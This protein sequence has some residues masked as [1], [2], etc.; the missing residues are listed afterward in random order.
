MSNTTDTN[1]SV[2][3][4]K[5]ILYDYIIRGVMTEDV[6]RVLLPQGEPLAYERQLWD[7]KT[8][9]PRLSGTGKH[10]KEELTT[11][12][13]EMSEIIKDAVAFYN[14]YGGYILIGAR[15]SP[16]E[17]VGFHGD[18]DCD[19]LNRSI[20]AATGRGIECFF[21]TFPVENGSQK[22]I[23]LGLLFIPQRP[24][25]EVP[26]QFCKDAAEKANG[27]KAYSKNDIYFRSNDECIAAKSCEDYAF[28]FT[29]GRRVFAASQGL[30]SLPILGSNLGPRDP[31]FIEFIG[32][33]DYLAALWNWFLDRYHPVKLL[34]GIGGVGKTA[35]AREFCEQFARV[36]PFGFQRIVWL[37]A[38]RQ[39]YT[40]ISGHFVSA[41]RV[42]FENVDGLLR[43]MCLEL[44]LIEGDLPADLAREHLIDAAIEVLAEMPAL[45]VIDDIDSLEPEQQQDVFHTLLTVFG[46]TISKSRVGSRALLT[47]RLDLGA[48][49]GQVIRVKGLKYEEFL[50][51]IRI[52]CGALELSL[53]VDRSSK[54]I[55]RFHRV[56]EGSPTFA[57]SIL[58]LVALGEGIDS[59]LTKWE[60]SDGEEVR[61]FAFDRELGQLADTTT[62]V[63]YALCVLS[64]SNLLEL[65]RVLSRTE[66]QIRDDFAELRKYHLISHAE[67]HLPGGARVSV[68]TSIR[69]MQYILKTKVRDPRRIETACARARSAET[70][71][72]DIGPYVVRIVSLW[73]NNEP[74]EA[75]SLAEML[76]RQSP[77][78]GDVKCLL[79]RA[80]LRVSSPDFRKAELALRAAQHLGCKRPELLPLWVET[81]AKLGDWMGLLAI[82]SF[83]DKDTPPRE[84]LLGRAEA[85]KRLAEIDRRGGN[86]RSAAER[87][88]EGG[89]EIDNVFRL[90]KAA[91][92]VPELRLLRKEF[93]FAY[94]GLVDKLTTKADDYID[95]W[96]AS[97]ECFNSFVRS[98][99]ILRLGVTRL[100][101]WWRAVESR[102]DVSSKSA[103]AIDVQISRLHHMVQTL[104]EHESSDQALVVD[105]EEAINDLGA[106]R[107]AYLS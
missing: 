5:T 27:K 1:G 69:M 61:K 107:A 4:H 57:S 54:R 59:A 95:V 77:N 12:R 50:D 3:S 47:A 60:R 32:R 8:Q 25:R 84:I 28:L 33:E 81:K 62:N 43:E 72:R 58:R 90:Q 7:Y 15:N 93:F 68:P 42:D 38:K 98:P 70:K 6:V 85:Y 36:A 35:L 30:T 75:L 89:K 49:P 86:M 13:G 66:Q 18:F 74:Q 17:L 63:L 102:G 41:T 97:V 52:T 14:S 78:L 21:K 34:A 22:Q 80:H 39:F 73:A 88:L 64:D 56:A 76:D 83:S 11:F 65:S 106:R 29:P 19:E 55:Q 45:V 51:F 2:F 24:D 91:G 9:L 103:A 100:R 79:G 10:S 53:S 96:L 40:A 82:T 99:W 31:G 94:M 44:G 92:A 104:R 105:L 101:D 20:A 26:A 16:C 67:A 23:T 46:Q 37:S 48:A 87:Y 71:V